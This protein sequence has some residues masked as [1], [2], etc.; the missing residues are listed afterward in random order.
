[1]TA[2]HLSALMQQAPLQGIEYTIHGDE[3]VLI[4]H[5]ASLE[6][7][8]KKSIC[9]LAN[10]KYFPLLLSSQATAVIMPQR[11]LDEIKERQIPISFTV[12]V[13]EDP[14]LM[15]ARLSQYFDQERLDQ[16]HTGISDKAEIHPTAKLGKNVTIGP[17]AVIEKDVV[18]GDNTIISAGCF[19]GASTVIGHHNIL[20][21]NVTIYHHV[22]IGNQCIIHSGVVIGADGFGNA[23]DHTV[24]KGAWSK[25]AQ[26]GSVQIGDKVEIGANTTIDRGAIDDTIIKDGARIDNLVMIAHNVHIGRHTA[27]AGCVAIAGSTHIGDHCILGGAVMMSGHL[28]IADG[29]TFSGGSSVMSNIKKPGQYT[30]VFPLME[31]KE[32]QKNAAVVTQLASLRKRIQQLEHQLKQET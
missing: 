10:P 20:Y 28:D 5:I 30:S 14:Y 4:E 22:T 21:P 29:V 12:V 32:W 26:L 9:F 23:P 2:I 25:I 7:A 19:V 13:C 3:Q 18:I 27:V 17:F 1:M 8:D 24:E 6:K 16:M 15:F 31:H 11:G